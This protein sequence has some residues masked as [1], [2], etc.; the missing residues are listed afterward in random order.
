MKR[1]LCL[2]ALLLAALLTACG[3][4]SNYSAS[5]DSAPVASSAVSMEA[6]SEE[7]FASESIALS[8]GTTLSAAENAKIIRTAYFY[9]QSTQFD[10][11]V[12]ALYD[13]VEAQGGYFETASV[14]NGRYYSGATTR[15]GCYTIRIPQDRFDTFLSDIGSVA[16]IANH[17]VDI[18]DVGEAYYDTELHLET[19]KTKHERLLAL[20]AQAT[21]MEDI[22][23]LE[24]ALSDVE[25]EIQQYTSTLN[26]YDGLINYSTITVDLREVARITEE[27]SETDSLGV[28]LSA[29]FSKGWMNF[30]DGLADL[31][32]WI[33]YHLIG[34]IIFAAII[35]VAVILLKKYRFPEKKKPIS[36][37]ADSKD[38]GNDQ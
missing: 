19:L 32:V 8:P 27:T 36:P 21:V 34:C 1:T 6:P 37:K 22:I 24:S 3:G 15:S 35:V 11:A 28:R 29:A 18:E 14:D 7:G 9:L 31:A 2:L 26:R 23:A 5:T 4:G 33:A 12:A 30:C 20:L 13:L 10:E 38:N 25:Y 16:H 17:S